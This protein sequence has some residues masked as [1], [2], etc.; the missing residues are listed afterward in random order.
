MKVA[1]SST[2]PD[3]EAQIDMRFGRC[4]YF[5]MVDTESL[6]FEALDNA[7]VAAAGGAG[8]R[9]AQLIA[10]KGSEALISGNVGPNAFNVLSAAG[11]K[12][13]SQASGSIKEALDKLKNGELTETTE[14]NVG[15]KF[16]F[17]GGR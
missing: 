12:V 9:S 14:P 3:L 1:I 8:I 11:I 4:R 7:N 5:I 16:G 6:E 2:G 10:D 13:Y 15:N 17:G